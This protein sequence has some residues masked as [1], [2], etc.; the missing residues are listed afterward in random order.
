MKIPLI[1]IR[2]FAGED[3]IVEGAVVEMEGKVTEVGMEGEGSI[4][5]LLDGIGGG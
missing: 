5:I 1:Y 3:G 4:E 2:R